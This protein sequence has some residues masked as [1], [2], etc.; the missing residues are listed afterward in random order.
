LSQIVCGIPTPPRNIE[1]ENEKFQKIGARVVPKERKNSHALITTVFVF[2]LNLYVLLPLL[3][4][5]KN[6][7]LRKFGV[8]TFEPIVGLAKR[9]FVCSP[10]VDISLVVPFEEHN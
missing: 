8:K 10:P 2:N 6:E 5:L 9:L 7:K 1:R 3:T 4:V